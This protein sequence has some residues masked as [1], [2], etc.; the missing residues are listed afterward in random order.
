MPYL[1]DKILYPALILLLFSVVSLLGANIAEYGFGLLPCHLCLYQ[2]VP[3]YIVLPLIVIALLLPKNSIFYTVI[4]SLGAIIIL[5]GA[6]IAAYHV[7]VEQGIIVTE[8]SCADA[9][10][11]PDATL[12]QMREQLFA[13]P[14]I[15]CDTPQ[16]IFLGLSMAAWNLLASLIVGSTAL[17]MS[18]KYFLARRT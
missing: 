9:V 14:G 4:T 15:P 3:H 5:G 13:T 6:G 16:F 11:A 12:K 1:H 18:I 8:T 2:R 17:I 10:I 7:G